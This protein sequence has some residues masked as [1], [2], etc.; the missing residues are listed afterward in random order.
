M[1]GFVERVIEDWLTKADERSYQLSFASHLSRIGHNVRYVS[2]HS[3]LEHG[4]DL[5]TTKGREIHAYQLKAGNIDKGAWR[6]IRE[7]VREAAIIP[8]DIP[9]LPQ[10]VPDYVYLVLTGYVSDVVQNEISLM[11]R[12][13]VRKKY[14]KIRIINLAELVA[15]FVAVFDSFLPSSIQLFH[16]LVRLYLRDGREPCDKP[17]YAA[18]LTAVMNSFPKKRPLGRSLSDLVVAAEFSSA[19]ARRSGTS[20]E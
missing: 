13:L 7:E 9:G 20:W 3:A 4:K 1:S 18:A 10:R 19:S 5:V 16:E 11:N 15:A 2:G 17:A 8:I 14:A 6:S 12:D